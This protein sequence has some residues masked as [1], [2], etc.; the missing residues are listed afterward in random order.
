MI[1]NEGLIMLNK[2]KLSNPLTTDNTTIETEFEIG[3]GNELLIIP[4]VIA[5]ELQLS[6]IDKRT[7]K[8]ENG[9]IVIE[10][11]TMH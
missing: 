10:H 6:E 8:K 1:N 9:E 4:E 5:N 11:S 7:Y 2:F 3:T